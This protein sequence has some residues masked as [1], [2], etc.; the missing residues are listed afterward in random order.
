MLLLNPSPTR[1]ATHLLR[2]MSTFFLKDALRVTVHSQKFIA[3]KLRKEEVTVTMEKDDQSF[4][5]R[6]IFIKTANP[7]LIF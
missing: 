6:K 2:M 7:L 3:L 1:F 4:H 5:Q